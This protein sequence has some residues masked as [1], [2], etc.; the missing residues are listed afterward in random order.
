MKF[1]FLPELVETGIVA[2]DNVEA[3]HNVAKLLIQHGY[4]DNDYPELVLKREKEYP[5]G[6]LTKSVA[7]A[8]PHSF[9]EKI[10]GNHVAIGVLKD[11][12]FFRNM[13]DVDQ[14]INVKIIFMLA[15]SKAKEQLEMLKILME[16]FKNEHLL[17]DIA[18]MDN[19]NTICEKL[20]A[21]I[22]EM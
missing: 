10:H 16:V 22:E 14:N 6:L 13:E 19:R 11:S 12:V 2:I 18:C 5:T 7:I 17:H 9:D 21:F 4:V 1:K 8:I 15:V 20:N 3:I